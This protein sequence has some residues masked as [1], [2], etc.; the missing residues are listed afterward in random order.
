MKK[1]LLT[2]VSTLILGIAQQAFAQGF[3]ATPYGN[4][5]VQKF[6]NSICRKPF[7]VL[8]YTNGDVSMAGTF[9]VTF[10]P[11]QFQLTD[12]GSFTFVA[13]NILTKMVN[14]PTHI[15]NKLVFSGE[16]ADGSNSFASFTVKFNGDFGPNPQNLTHTMGTPTFIEIGTSNLSSQIAPNGLLEAPDANGFTNTPQFVQLAGVLTAD[17]PK[18]QFAPGSEIVT[19]SG[20]AK[21]IVNPNRTLNLSRTEVYGCNSMWQGISVLGHGRLE[22]FGSFTGETVVSDAIT[23]VTLEN[24]SSLYVWWSSLKGNRTGIRVNPNAGTLQN[25]DMSVTRLTCTGNPLMDGSQAIAGLD[26][27]DLN[28]VH[29]P[30]IFGIFALYSTIEGFTNGLLANNARVSLQAV[31]FNNMQQNGILAKNNSSITYDGLNLFGFNNMQRGILATNTDLTVRK[32]DIKNVGSGIRC[33]QSLGDLTNLNE[34]KINASMY[35][36]SVFADGNATGEIYKNDIKIPSSWGALL[37]GYGIGLFDLSGN[38]STNDWNILDNK[39]DVEARA[40]ITAVDF[41]NAKIRANP[42]IKNSANK[43]AIS[44]YGGYQNE[45]ECNPNI[46]SGGYGVIIEE[47]SLFDHSCNTVT[48]GGIALQVFGDCEESKVR[49]NNLTGVQH[50]LAYGDANLPFANTG[51]QVYHRNRFLGSSSLAEAINFSN[52]DIAT[53]SQYKVWTQSGS[54]ACPIDV[55]LMPTFI[56]STPDWFNEEYSQFHCVF[57]CASGGCTIVPAAQ[58]GG[59][60]T[61]DQLVR[62]G[63]WGGG[64]LPTGAEWNA[65]RYLFRKLNAQASLTS[66]FGNFVQSEQNGSVGR[67]TEYE[68][69]LRNTLSIST[70]NQSALQQLQQE[71]QV[72]LDALGQQSVWQWQNNQWVFDA[73][74]QQQVNALTVSLGQ[75]QD[76]IDAIKST[77]HQTVLANVPALTTENAAIPASEVYESN[78]QFVNALHLKLLQFGIGYQPNSTE[79]LQVGAIAQQCPQVGGLAVYQARAMLEAFTGEVVEGQS[80]CM[81]TI[82]RSA[83]S[84]TAISHTL[85][86]PN[87]ASQQV[88]VQSTISL[89]QIVVLNT[90]GQLLVDSGR[91]DLG[92]NYTL[93]ITQWANGLYYAQV[94]DQNG[95]TYTHKIIVSK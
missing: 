23:A 15:F 66:G 3:V 12:P 44:I 49:G 8:V 56:A 11:T 69:S 88:V 22:L 92:L 36:I 24:N 71:R 32:A 47:S 42:L 70:A 87:P 14:T 21:I 52:F 5:E 89:S 4:I 31:Q 64:T 95:H 91:K 51:E 59:M 90:L 17:L 61:K 30:F 63:I 43:P 46:N 28:S 74:A 67:S 57:S 40:A 75:K 13:P 72:L 50:D 6:G 82:E 73:N 19:V 34:N 2:L 65:K 68:A 20:G 1:T 39:I 60:T 29:F 77:L 16:F 55:E 48:A 41:E 26:F 53:N 18:Y 80:Q 78:Q 33:E 93:D 83:P 79:L 35:G 25:I 27:T 38:A 54:N 94:T 86:A 9:T 76:G 58:T 7:D 84:E 37:K 10:D 62:D 85:I 81:N 45:V